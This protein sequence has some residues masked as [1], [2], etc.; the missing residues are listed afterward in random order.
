MAGVHGLPPQGPHSLGPHPRAARRGRPRGG[1]GARGGAFA[2]M[3]LPYFAPSS[4]AAVRATALSVGFTQACA[5]SAIAAACRS[6]V[7][8]RHYVIRGTQHCFVPGA[9]GPGANL[10]RAPA[11]EPPMQDGIVL[12]VHCSLQDTQ[13]C[14]RCKIQQKHTALPCKVAKPYQKSSALQAIRDTPN[15]A[16]FAAAHDRG[17]CYGRPRAPARH[18]CGIQAGAGQR[19]ALAW[20]SVLFA[21]WLLVTCLRV[22]YLTV[23]GCG[24]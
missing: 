3:C 23:C 2:H 16:S 19:G 8:Q 22:V 11:G 4:R 21:Y 10:P 6:T 12:C 14:C 24:V 15:T 18:D 7:C 17:A 20:G 1:V 5:A 9:H 13:H